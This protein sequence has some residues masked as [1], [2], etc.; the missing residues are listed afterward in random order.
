[1][2]EKLYDI[3]IFGATGFTGKLVAEY[4]L[5]QYGLKNNKLFN[6]AIA[7]RDIKKLE[8]LKSDLLKI[9]SDA[10]ELDLLVADSFDEKTINKIT[11]SARLIISTVGPYIKY[12]KKLVS[13]CAKNGTHYCDLTGE[14]PFIRESIDIN[15]KIA[16]KNNCKIIHSCGFDSIPSDLGVLLMQKEALKKYKMPCR[17]I[18]YYVRGTKGGFS[19]GTIA[20]MIAIS[21]HI[22][23][24]PSLSSL[25]GNPYAL[26]SA[27]FNGP[28]A[29]SLRSNKW[30]NEAKL[31][32][33]PFVMAGINTRIVRWSNE[34]AGFEYGKEFLYSEVTSFP[35]GVKGY[36]KSLS[37]LISLALTKI[38]MSFRPTFL[39]LRKY[40]LP[41][42]GQGPTKYE[43]ENGF[44]KILLIGKSGVNKISCNVIGDSDPG[45]SG[46]AKMITE[47]ALSIILDQ[48]DLPQKF[49]VLTPAAGIGL[50]L[51]K[52]LESK[53]I[54]FK[55]C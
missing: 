40:I 36:I 42:P 15:D 34:L 6:W 55:V 33:A 26:N 43:R 32:L 53:G 17:E 3:I 5:E 12:G 37:M 25:L 28:P 44:F 16:K 2:K 10:V 1:M 52:R 7:G 39:F 4:I 50:T 22:K 19:G 41:A 18:K 29:S 48:K 38:L 20:S 27:S 45:Y 9:N 24:N 35:R 47:S 49:G 54:V 30:D 14:V 11:E 23:S 51:I 8:N 31:W 46:T 21:E 13:S